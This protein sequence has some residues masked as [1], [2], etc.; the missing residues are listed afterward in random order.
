M[1]R[2][3]NPGQKHTT[4][5]CK[6]RFLFSELQHMSTGK[7][8][9]KCKQHIGKQRNMQEHVRMLYV[10]CVFYIDVLFNLVN[11][12]VLQGVS[13]LDVQHIL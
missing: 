3:R 10:S 4:L 9:G 7:S 12:V 8:I 2:I 6:T 5:I 1:S 11:T 13:L